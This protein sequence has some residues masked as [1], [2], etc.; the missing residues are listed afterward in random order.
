MSDNQE[1][2]WSAWQWDQAKYYYYRYHINACGQPEYE[3]AAADPTSGQASNSLAALEYN[4]QSQNPNPSGGYSSSSYQQPAY[5]VNPNPATGYST[6]WSQPTNQPITSQSTGRAGN[7]SAG[8]RY[9]QEETYTKP[10]YVS[11][12][13]I[14]KS[15]LTLVEQVG[16]SA[17][18]K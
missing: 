14:S 1:S 13:I 9:Y 4:T 2:A 17:F 11:S 6:N 15:E 18:A 8:N 7:H 5:Q 12:P 10:G 16:L 3:T